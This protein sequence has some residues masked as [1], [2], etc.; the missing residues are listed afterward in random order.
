MHGTGIK[1]KKNTDI[2]Q[3]PAQADL[4]STSPLYPNYEFTNSAAGIR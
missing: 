1:I 4:R 3:V 2:F